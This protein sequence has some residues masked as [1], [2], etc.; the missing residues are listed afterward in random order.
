MGEFYS[1]G[2]KIECEHSEVIAKAIREKPP[3]NHSKLGRVTK[4]VCE[5]DGSAEIIKELDPKEGVYSKESNLNL[6]D[7]IR[8]ES[9]YVLVSGNKRLRKKKKGGQSGRHN[10]QIIKPRTYTF[11]EI[12]KPFNHILHSLRIKRY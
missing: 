1:E 2:D 8:S 7:K 6:G 5:R 4:Y 11:A 3:I 10:S 9:F 12:T